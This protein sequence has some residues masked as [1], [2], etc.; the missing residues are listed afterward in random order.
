MGS[1]KGFNT[2]QILYNRK[3]KTFLIVAVIIVAAYLVGSLIYMNLWRKNNETRS[4]Q[5]LGDSTSQ[6]AESIN[7]IAESNFELLRSTAASLAESFEN[8]KEA[9]VVLINTINLSNHFIR[10]GYSESDG[11]ATF[12]DLDEN[13]YRGVDLTGFD[14]FQKAMAGE[15]AVSYIFKD[16]WSGEQV[17]YTAVPICKNKLVCGVVY[18]V[19]TDNLLMG[20]LDSPVFHST[21]T[22]FIVDETGAMVTHS[23]SADYSIDAG[24]SIFNSFQFADSEQSDATAFLKNGTTGNS[25][26]SYEGKKQVLTFK[27]LDFNGW[28]VASVVPFDTID[29]YYNQA[30]VDVS[31]IIFAAYFIFLF[32]MYYQLRS[33]IRNQR[34]LE[35]L[36]YVDLLTENRNYVKFHKDAVNLIEKNLGVKYAVWSYDVKS[37]NGINNIFGRAIGDRVLQRISNV[38]KQSEEQ[39]G[40]IFCRMA[41]DNYVGIRPYPEKDKLEEWFD[42]FIAVLALREVISDKKMHV[43][44]SMGIYCIED[45]DETHSLDD[46]IT[47]AAMARKEAKVLPGSHVLFFTTDMSNKLRWNAR[48]EAEA[49]EALQ[50]GDITFFLQPKVSIQNG[51]VITGAEALARWN[52]KEHG[53][54][55]PGEFIPLFERNGFVV[56]MGRVI[57]SRV[58]EW[59]VEYAKKGGIPLQISVNVS[60]QGMLQDDFLQYYSDTLRNYNLPERTIELEFTESTTMVDTR[61]FRE[62]VMSLHESGFICS[63]DDFGSGYSSLNILKELPIDVLKL[64]AIFFRN[65]QS[66]Q[67][68]HTV[69]TGFIRIARELQI[70]TV[71][72]GVETPEQ[73]F[74]LRSIGCDTIQGYVFSKPLPIDDFEKLLFGTRGQLKLEGK[75]KT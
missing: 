8:D 75:S 59:Y 10:M 72:E 42:W 67:R 35:R 4:Y 1:M 69:I 50:R 64:D 21:G 40:G 65:S 31:V 44:A 70:F 27:P 57:F 18:G 5:S 55:P 15:M 25:I 2:M 23:P 9:A 20:I 24:D 62:T 52:H 37:F 71:A 47:R 26:A 33:A 32:L 45:F 51:Y 11:I 46:M 48:L 60:R 22:Y 74:F 34:D 66:I 53:L 43:D 30:L 14:I 56:K 68:E 13:V 19:D 7:Q 41:A 63:I 36:A 58:C 12:V 6:T 29:E 38:F 3:F 17:I 16:E 54:I 39:D 28:M 49:E 73:V 61:F